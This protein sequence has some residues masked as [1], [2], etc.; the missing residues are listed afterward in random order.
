MNQDDLIGYVFDALE[1]A[2]QERI[3]AKIASDPELAK[4]VDELRRMVIPLAADDVIVPADDLAARTIERIA[5]HDSRR[6]T[7]RPITEWGGGNV[8]IRPLDFIVAATLFGVAALLAIPALIQLRGD[9]ERILC[10]EQFRRLGVALAMYAEQEHNQ[11]PFVAESGPMNNAGVFAIQL[12][13]RELLPDAKALVC[14]GANNSVVMVPDPK[15]W[16][17]SSLPHFERDH[18]RRYMGGS[19]GYL[20]GY[21]DSGKHLGFSVQSTSQPVMSDRP[22]RAEEEIQFVNSPNH[23]N[24]GQNVL[25]ADGSVRWLPRPQYGKDQ[26]FRNDNGDVGA[27]LHC[28]DAVIGVSES[29]PYSRKVDL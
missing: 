15:K 3:E 16:I 24:R 12:K 19:Y 1:P 27:G 11:L 5:N 22:P 13:E 10:A 26:L 25:Y 6:P 18:F 9:Q 4:K 29:T 23:A 2:E 28:T 7:V 20:L 8:T 21:Q 17:D 14:P